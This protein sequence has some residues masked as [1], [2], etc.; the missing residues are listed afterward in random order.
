VILYRKAAPL[1]IRRFTAPATPFWCATTVAPYGA[2]RAAPLAVDYLALR[3][4][5]AE[6]LEVSVTENVRSELERARALDGPVLVDAAEAAELVFRR[7]EEVL[8]FCEEQRL[9]ALYLASTEGVLPEARPDL[10][11]A[12]AAWP[13]D[14]PRLTSLFA[15][16]QVREMRWGVA[17]PLLHPATT[18]LASLTALADLAAK[19]RSSSTSTR[20]PSRRWPPT[21]RPSPRSFTRIS[22]RSSSPPSATS[23]PSPPSAACTTSSSP[24]AGTSAPTG[25]PPSSSPAPPPG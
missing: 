3:A 25:T 10:S 9:P 16:A 12:I 8:L 14:L 5:G 24:R 22:S 6:K 7:G 13:L 1:R 18:D 17:L 21:R 2:R 23:A 20:P 15:R 4:S 19:P 11:V